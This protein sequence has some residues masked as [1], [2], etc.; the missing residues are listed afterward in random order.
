MDEVFNIP[1]EYKNKPEV[2]LDGAHE[3]MGY[4]AYSPISSFLPDQ[5]P[6]YEDATHTYSLGGIIYR[7]A[8]TIVSQFYEGFNSQVRA[9]WMVY[10]YGHSVQYWLDKW[11]NVNRVSLDRGNNIHDEQEQF[12]YNR[13]FTRVTGD[14]DYPVFRRKPSV[15]TK[16][17]DGSTSIRMLVDGCYPELKVWNHDWCI[18]GRSD[19][20]TIETLNG[21]R[22]VHIEDYKTNKVIE[23]RGW[24]DRQGNER[25][26]LDPIQHLPDC[27]LTH[28][29][30]QLS[31]YQ[32]MFEYF[33]YL[34]GIR[35][36]I[37]FPHEIEGL[38]TPNPKPYELPYLR[39]EVLAMLTTLKHRL[40]L[41][42]KS[43]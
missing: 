13:G 17:A 10:R 19:K 3:R 29:T 38:G 12:L 11:K 26:M 40:W 23:D 9:E 5:E 8:T 15:S 39:D 25:M 24:I 30:L 35:R 14:R 22:Y 37:H 16:K 42:I 7:S 41:G 31:L 21:K 43:L 6:E 18:A 27:E 28:Y 2:W 20:P 34:P 36:I 4:K 1:P 32:Y 33:G